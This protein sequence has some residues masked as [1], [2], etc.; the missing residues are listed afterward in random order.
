MLLQSTSISLCKMSFQLF[1]LDGSVSG[2]VNQ[3]NNFQE[4]SIV[5][6]RQGHIQDSEVKIGKKWSGFTYDRS[7]A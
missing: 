6:G 4:A 7:E 5:V 1:C 2:H 3:K